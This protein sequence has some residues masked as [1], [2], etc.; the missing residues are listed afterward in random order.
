MTIK[1]NKKGFTLIELLATIV[2]LG[3]IFSVTSV[4]IVSYYEKSKE[5]SSDAFIKQLEGYIDS[6]ITLYSSNFNFSSSGESKNKCHTN[7][8]GTETCNSVKLYSVTNNPNIETIEEYLSN[9]EFINPSSSV[10]CNTD[11][12][13]LS[14]YRDSDYVYCFKLEKI[15]ETSCIDDTV[16]TCNR[17]YK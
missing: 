13:K 5:K 14:I 15:N 6:Y 9:K 8:S 12:T 11:N 2:I 4:T 16:N 7:I 1:L 3:L 17:I 10:R